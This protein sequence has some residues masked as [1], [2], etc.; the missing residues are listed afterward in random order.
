M[1][2][3]DLGHYLA[4]QRVSTKPQC[5]VLIDIILAARQYPGEVGNLH[6]QSLSGVQFGSKLEGV[7]PETK[8]YLWLTHGLRHQIPKL[9]SLRG[10]QE[11]GVFP[12][13]PGK[14]QGASPS[15]ACAVEKYSGLEA[16]IL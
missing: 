10:F 15:D 12:T 6:T 16:T 1:N 7:I 11:L 14:T 3:A 9:T 2:A 13:I 8:S 5:S 4:V